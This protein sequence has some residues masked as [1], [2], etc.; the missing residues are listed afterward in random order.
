[1]STQCAFLS[2]QTDPIQKIKW[3]D[4]MLCYLHLKTNSLSYNR[5]YHKKVIATIPPYTHINAIRSVFFLYFRFSHSLSLSLFYRLWLLLFCF[6]FK[7]RKILI[8]I[9]VSAI[10]FFLHCEFKKEKNRKKNPLNCCQNVIFSWSKI[11]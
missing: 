4:V 7:L 10:I 1:M 9:K 5:P 6:Q 3:N 11:V 8:K 2:K